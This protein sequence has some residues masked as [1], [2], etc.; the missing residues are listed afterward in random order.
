[1]RLDKWLK[2]ARV[3]KRRPVAHAICEQGRVTVNGRAAKPALKLKPGDKL[4]IRFG[5]RQ[6]S[7]T[8]LGVPEKQVAAKLASELYQ[9]DGELRLEEASKALEAEMP[10]QE[11]EGDDEDEA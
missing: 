4:V 3:I 5:Q 6:L 1:M 10:A 7:L 8:V 11:G 2:V 9:V